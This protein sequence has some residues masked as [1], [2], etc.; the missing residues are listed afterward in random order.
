MRTTTWL[1]RYRTTDR[2]CNRPRSGADHKHDNHL[3]NHLQTWFSKCHIA[4]G[5][6][7]RWGTLG[8]PPNQPYRFDLK[9][10]QPFQKIPLTL[11]GDFL[12]TRSC[13]LDNVAMFYRPVHSLVEKAR[14]PICQ[15]LHSSYGSLW[16]TRCNRLDRYY[17]WSSHRMFL[18]QRHYRTIII[19]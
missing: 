8:F 17:V 11:G 12:G 4:T 13:D 9:K 1:V 10:K 2:V 16:W 6:F 18:P 19:L 7:I 5:P 14:W 15:G 3:R